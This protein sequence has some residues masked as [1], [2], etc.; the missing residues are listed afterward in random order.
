[1]FEKILNKLFHR[2]DIRSCEMEIYLK[3]WYIFKSKRLTL[4]VHKFEKSDE[5]MALHDHP[6]AFFVIPIWRGYYEYNLKGKSRSYPIISMRYRNRDYRHRVVLIDR[7]P[8]WSLFFHG[9]K[10]GLWGFWPGGKFVNNNQW[11]IDNDCG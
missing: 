5:D 8:S 1:M 3:R 6:W 11:W 10:S 4:F 9:V 2:R 7:K